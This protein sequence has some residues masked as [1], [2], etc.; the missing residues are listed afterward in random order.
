VRRLAFIAGAAL[1]GTALAAAACGGSDPQVVVA[2]DAMAPALPDG[3]MVSYRPAGLIQRGDVV[4]FEW[5]DGRWFIKRVVA[6]GGETVA[7][8][9]GRVWI[10]GA[11]LDEPYDVSPASYEVEPL[12]V[13]PGFLY[14]LGDARDQSLDSHA[15]GPIDSARVKGVV[16]LED[17]GR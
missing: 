15:F 14:V 3:T 8:L 13:P 2:G 9:D 1:T 7:V 6:L 4:V 10:D 11:P 5:E 17:V 16:R 12:E